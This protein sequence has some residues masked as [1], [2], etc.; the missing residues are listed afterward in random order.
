MSVAEHA[1]HITGIIRTVLG[2][3]VNEI[4]NIEGC[5]VIHWTTDGLTFSIP[6]DYQSDITKKI[7]GKN[8]NSLKLEE[9]H[10]KLMKKMNGLRIIRLLK[11]GARK[12]GLNDEN[13]LEIKGF[14]D[15]VGS[16]TTRGNWM[17][18]KEKT[19]GLTRGNLGTK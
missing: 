5:E 11:N 1:S 18:W 17:K 15:K 19:T 13:W 2:A 12:V 8:G 16:F 14:D 4:E 3:M 6:W 9:F 10:P 7:E